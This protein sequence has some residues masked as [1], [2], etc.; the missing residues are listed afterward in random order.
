MTTI[1]Y[2]DIIPDSTTGRLITTIFII[3]C[4]VLFS[5]WIGIIIELLSKKDEN[6]KIHFKSI[7]E[8]IV[9]IGNLSQNEKIL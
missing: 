3:I 6:I 5:K 4:F 9:I 1:G 7:H 8:Y 2:G